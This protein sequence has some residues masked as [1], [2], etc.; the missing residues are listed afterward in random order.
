VHSTLE[1]NPNFRSEYFYRI[2]K[3]KV[4]CSLPIFH[5]ANLFA[6]CTSTAKSRSSA[7]GIAS[8]YGLADRGVGVRVPVGSRIFT[9]PYRPEVRVR[10][11]ALPN[12]LRSNGTGTGSTQPREYN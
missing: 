10:F 3:K 7:V 9:S 4:Q 5:N 12:F 8:A 1:Y 6:I 11:P 2:S